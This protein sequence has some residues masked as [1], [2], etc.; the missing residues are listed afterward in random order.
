MRVNKL[1]SDPFFSAKGAA[2]LSNRQIPFMR[3][4]SQLLTWKGEELAGSKLK[5]SYYFVE[6][7][8]M[9]KQWPDE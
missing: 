8:P 3:R 1:R 7:K 4:R 6:R 5:D 2:G 9:A